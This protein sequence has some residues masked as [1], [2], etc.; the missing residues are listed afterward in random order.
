MT[1]TQEHL[2]ELIAR[3]SMAHR[4]VILPESMDEY[5]EILLL[6]LRYLEL[7]DDHMEK[8]R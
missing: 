7:W 2:Q 6:A 8:G 3:A 1:I 5:R 4:A